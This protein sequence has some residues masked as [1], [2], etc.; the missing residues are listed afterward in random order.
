MVFHTGAGRPLAQELGL[1]ARSMAAFGRRDFDRQ[2][3]RDWDDA[4]AELVLLAR[5][6]RLLLVLDE[7]PELV[8]SSPELP[9]VLRALLDTDIEGLKILLAGSAVRLMWALEEQRAPLYGRSDLSWLLHPFAPHEAALMLSQLPPAERARVY[10]I[11]GGVPLYLS[12]WDTAA[13]LEQNVAR[14]V[15]A[16]DGRLLLEGDLVLATE[17]EAGELPRQ[18]LQ[19]IAAGRTRHGEIND[20]VRAESARTLDRLIALRLVERMTPVTDDPRRS[21]R[22]LYRIADPFLAFW[23]GVVDRHRSAIE[24]G[25]GERILPALLEDLDRHAG[26]V[27]EEA[28]RQH[29]YRLA[30][31]GDLGGDVAAV[32]RWWRDA[33]EPT[34][35]DAV[36]LAGRGRT[37][38]LAV[39]AKWAAHVDARRLV[40][41]LRRRAA[42]VPGA[43][44]D[45][46][47]GLAARE[48]VQHAN[49]GLLTVTAADVFA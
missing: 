47:L 38:V 9:G 8:A 36:A 49:P 44:D 45:L 27:W 17:A 42:A 37:P 12:W 33:P 20:A 43:P 31:L 22:R 21:R 35:V 34:E 29:L 7:F 41:G 26:P 6:K 10:T 40:P 4:L 19:A 25:L 5:E 18:V 28:V 15:A 14:L 13:S 3:L 39:E 16:P 11:T 32:G 30:R 1:L 24:R 46:R 23:L 48:S 2:P